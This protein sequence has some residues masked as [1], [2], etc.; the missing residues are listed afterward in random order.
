MHDEGVH[1]SCFGGEA[2]NA[3]TALFGGAELELEERF[4]VG[5][6]DAEVVRHRGFCNL[7]TSY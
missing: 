1:L 5:V 6:D 4:V 3:I 2:C 7:E